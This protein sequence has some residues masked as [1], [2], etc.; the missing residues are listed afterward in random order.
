M[1]YK[2]KYIF[3][4]F[5]HLF[6][7]NVSKFKYACHSVPLVDILRIWYAGFSAVKS[8]GYYE[9]STQDCSR[10]N[11]CVTIYQHPNWWGWY[12][13]LTFRNN[14]CTTLNSWWIGWGSRVSGADSHNTC[15]RL[16]TEKDCTG[17]SLRIDPS[18]EYPGELREV[19]FEDKA[20]SVSS[21]NRVSNRK[22]YIQ[23]FLRIKKCTNYFLK[24]YLN[25][26]EILQ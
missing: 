15:V 2:V 18:F 5:C 12:Q 24:V 14:E 4:I 19:N 23:A 21:C 17:Y 11:A 7:C 3:W 13:C 8:Q 20:Q 6:F 25:V 10:K 16:Y 22:K 9:C 26:Q 1:F